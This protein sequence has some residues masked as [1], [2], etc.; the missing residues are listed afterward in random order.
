[1]PG[2][3]TRTYRPGAFTGTVIWAAA[4]PLTS[5]VRTWGSAA[6]TAGSLLRN[7]TVET[8]T[9]AGNSRSVQ[10]SVRLNSCTDAI[11]ACCGNVTCHQGAVWNSAVWVTL[12]SPQAPLL[13]PSTARSGTPP[14]ST[15]DWAT[16][17]RR[18]R[19]VPARGTGGSAIGEPYTSTSAS[20]SGLPSSPAVCTR[21]YRPVR[22]S[23]S[24]V[25]AET[26]P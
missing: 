5:K 11:V 21:T 24:S 23:G 25:P 15:L 8:N 19:L 1:M 9:V 4:A 26:T 13:L 2:S 10:Q 7:G 3:C 12:P 16:G 17:C 6:S 20:D 22:F 14:K 18:A